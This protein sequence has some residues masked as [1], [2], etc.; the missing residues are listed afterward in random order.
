MRGRLN[1]GWL[2]TL[3][4]CVGVVATG[5]SLESSIFG[6]S[7]AAALCIG[8]LSYGLSVCGS[9]IKTTR[10]ILFNS[11]LFT[12]VFVLLHVGLAIFWRHFPP[13]YWPWLH[14]IYRVW[15]LS[16]CSA[17]ILAL[18]VVNLLA[19]EAVGSIGGVSTRRRFQW[20]VIASASVLGLA[21][22]ANLL[23]TVD[24][25]D[26]FFP[27]GVPFAFFTEGGYAGGEDLS[28]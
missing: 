8:L 18:I 2:A 6:V 14:R 25:A 7:I 16:E 23:R 26:C 28:G 11:A 13:E 22:I 15:W 20:S 4:C 3:V 1:G 27:Y 19:I 10:L 24:C 17:I 9:R 12:V 21:N 5:L